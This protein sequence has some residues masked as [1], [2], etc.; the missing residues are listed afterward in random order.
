[1]PDVIRDEARDTTYPL[2][3]VIKERYSTQIEDDSSSSESSESS[4]EEVRPL[5][6]SERMINQF[7][8][9]VGMEEKFE[10]RWTLS[11]FRSKS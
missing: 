2:L 10:P 8:K 11:D 7:L 1:M 5:D 3:K 4:D 6:V 9:Q